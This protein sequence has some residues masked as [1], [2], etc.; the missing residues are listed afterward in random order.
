MVKKF[1]KSAKAWIE[2]LKQIILQ[3]RGAKESK[4]ADSSLKEE[5]FEAERKK[6]LTKAMQVLPQKKHLKVL[7][8]Y[9]RLEYSFGELEK[10]RTSFDSIVSNFPKRY[11]LYF[12][13]FD[14]EICAF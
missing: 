8:H 2:Y 4:T 3:Q 6:V 5:E 10:A 13:N 1:P 12:F 7:S 11:I 9:A 14:G